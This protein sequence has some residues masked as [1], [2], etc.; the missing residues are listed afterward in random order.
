M[1]HFRPKKFN[2]FHKVKVTYKNRVIY[3][4]K[5]K[6]GEYLI[7]SLDFFDFTTSQILVCKAL[8][9]KLL[10]AENKKLLGYEE[11]LS[12]NQGKVTTIKDF[13]KLCSYKMPLFP[14]FTDTEKPRETRMGKGKGAVSVHFFPVKQGKILF[15]LRNINESLAKKCLKLIQPKLP[16]RAKLVASIY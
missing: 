8:I 7:K 14:D 9:T 6:Y 5:P 4:Q 16:G 3:R 13:D 1:F 11:S 12:Y 10:K 2:K 15:E